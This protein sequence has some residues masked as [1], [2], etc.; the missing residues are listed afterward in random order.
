MR[1]LLLAGTALLAFSATLTLESRTASAIICAD[2][3]ERVACVGPRGAVVVKKPVVVCK[4][5]W[6][7]GVKVKRCK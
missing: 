3:V 2:G 1:S 4:T 7:N 5:V 6:V